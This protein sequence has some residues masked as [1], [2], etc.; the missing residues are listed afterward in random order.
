MYDTYPDDDFCKELPTGVTEVELTLELSS[1]LTSFSTSAL[2]VTF[3][4][5]D[6]GDAFSALS[7]NRLVVF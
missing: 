5:F 7:E 4:E 3:A 2:G 1:F 6:V